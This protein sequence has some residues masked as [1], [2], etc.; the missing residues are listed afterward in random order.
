MAID[1]HFLQYLETVHE[2]FLELVN[3]RPIDRYSLNSDE[4]IPAVYLF[5]EGDLHLYV[6]RTNNL[7]Q[8][9][10]NHCNPGSQHNQAVFAFKLARIATNNLE[11]IYVGDGTRKALS[12]EAGFAKAFSAAKLQVGKMHLRYVR[13]DDQLE[14]TLLEIYTAKVLQTPH[15]DFVRPR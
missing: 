10:G 6:G 8:R 12:V 1:P 2:K 15:N 7:K 9:L 4:K 13:V 14:Q 3:S 11:A 5:S